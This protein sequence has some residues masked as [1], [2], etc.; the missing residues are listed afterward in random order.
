MP[1]T[2][3]ADAPM[4]KRKRTDDHDAVLPPSPSMDLDPPTDPQPTA[5]RIRTGCNGN[6]WAHAR[7]NLSSGGASLNSRPASPPSPPLSVS[8][9]MQDHD[10]LEAARD[11]FQFEFAHEILTRNNELR[12]IEQETAKCQIAL[13]QLRRCHLIPYPTHCPTPAQMLD[14][15]SGRG[16][17]VRPRPGATVPKWCTPF[18]V[19]DGPYAR[20]YAKWLIPDPVFDG[21]LPNWPGFAPPARAVKS[22]ATADA[23]ATRNSISDS[24]KPRATRGIS[25]QKLHSLSSGYPQPKDRAGPCVLKR[26]DGKVVKLVCTDCHRDNFSST[27]G[28]INHCRIAHKRDYKSHDEAAIHCG[29]PIEVDTAAPPPTAAPAKNTA[30]AAKAGPAVH[31]SGGIHIP[32]TAAASLPSSALAT[33]LTAGIT[34]TPIGTALPGHVY[35]LAKADGNTA[36]TVLDRIHS[37]YKTSTTT[38]TGVRSNR[39]K[40]KKPKATSAAFVGSDKTPFLSRFLEKKEFDG[41]LD[42]SVEDAKEV[43]DFNDMAWYVDE[44]F[45][46]FALDTPRG[47]SPAATTVKRAPAKSTP[48]ASRPSGSQKAS[49]A[50]H[51]P[52]GRQIVDYVSID[53]VGEP[54]DLSPIPSASNNAPS[55]VS[56]D[57]EY[58]DSDDGSVS[59]A[60]DSDMGSV[61]DV[62]EI[63]IDE[64]EDHAHNAPRPLRR[65]SGSVKLKKDEPKHVTFVSPV[66]GSN[67]GRR[68]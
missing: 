67:N 43:T 2:S 1:A 8:L 56:D 22:Y 47:D 64:D 24:S 20:H 50:D 63:T 13:E 68:N 53:T 15:A 4:A 3:A 58:D 27:Q 18:G 23:R 31:K 62:A 60:S 36:D 19:V 5:K 6:A 66:K 25:G 33:P 54:M 35:T 12:L 52:F 49:G 17:A 32:A 42:A 51:I 14:I 39:V 55:L 9:A 28:F 59:E 30:A 34:C 37:T 29:H 38:A 21:P 7:S 57:G 44:G 65:D 10:G 40:D 26:S 45:D 41:N 61:S 11:V 46:D 16:I 48:Q